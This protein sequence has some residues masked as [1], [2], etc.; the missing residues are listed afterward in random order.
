MI[1]VAGAFRHLLLVAL[2]VAL[3]AAAAGAQ[4]SAAAAPAAP[5]APADSLRW[6]AGC[7]RLSGARSVVE[8]QWMAPRGGEMLGVSRTVAGGAVREFEF[9][10]IYA[11]GDTLV[12]AARPSRQP[13]A[14]FRATTLS[15]GEVLFENPQHDFPQKVG[16]RLQPPDSL[17][18][19]IEGTT[20]GRHRV[21]SFPYRRVQC[22]EGRD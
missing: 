1:R 7:W 22:G 19:R 6:L 9:L 10:R 2:C 20:G 16:Y 17:I 11:R 5:T 15:A 18:A 13:P 4:G 3:P 14:E 8:E 21:V 12:Y